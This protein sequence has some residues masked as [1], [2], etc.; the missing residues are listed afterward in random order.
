MGSS[1]VGGVCSSRAVF[2][3]CL[4]RCLVNPPTVI[5]AHELPD[6]K[7]PFRVGAVRPD[8][9]GN[10][11]IRTIPSKPVPGGQVYDVVSHDGEL[12]DRLQL[13]P[14]YNL[15]GFGKGKV[16]YLSMRDVKGIHLARVRLR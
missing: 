5:P 9:D 12:V 15:V 7:P 8:M 4:S 13:P 11:W 6:Y 10:L 1:A 2:P 14:S 3:A 16:V